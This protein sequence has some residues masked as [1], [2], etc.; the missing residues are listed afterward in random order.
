MRL[1]E[2]KGSSKSRFYNIKSCP[3]KLIFVHGVESIAKQSETQ[4]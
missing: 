2:E 4:G 1:L 3:Q